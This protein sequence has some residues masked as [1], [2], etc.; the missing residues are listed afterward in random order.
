MS[1]KLITANWVKSIPKRAATDLRRLYK[2]PF[3]DF[4]NRGVSGVFPQAEAQKIVQVL[5]NVRERALV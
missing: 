2:N 4:H 5:Y 3:T 1:A